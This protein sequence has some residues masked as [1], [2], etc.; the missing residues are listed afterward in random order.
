MQTNLQGVRRVLGKKNAQ[1]NVN[2]TNV[3]NLRLVILME[4]F[5]FTLKL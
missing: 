3:F 2:R 4:V 1:G 5:F